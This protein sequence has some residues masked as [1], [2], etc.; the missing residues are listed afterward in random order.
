[1][2]KDDLIIG[3]INEVKSDIKALSQR[4]TTIEI[5]LALLW[6]KTA[7]FSGLAAAIVAGLFQLAGY[8]IA[9]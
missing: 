4:M 3:S 6:Q 8:L 7:F 9:K 1:M 5:K 2:E